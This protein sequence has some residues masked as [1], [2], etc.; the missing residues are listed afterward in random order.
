M[1]SDVHWVMV[2]G[3]FTLGSGINV[4]SGINVKVG[5]FRDKYTEIRS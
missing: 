5:T 1:S 4:R 2:Y 3:D